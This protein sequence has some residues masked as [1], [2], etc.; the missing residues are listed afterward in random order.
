MRKMIFVQKLKFHSDPG[1]GWVEISIQKINELGIGPKISPYSYISRD[2]QTAYLEEDC[3]AS[4][5]VNTLEKLGQAVD[6]QDI[7]YNSVC[8]IRNLPHYPNNNW[9]SPYK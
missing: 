1:H 8:F 7:N 2:G 5:L 4:T 9:I 6:F 3:D